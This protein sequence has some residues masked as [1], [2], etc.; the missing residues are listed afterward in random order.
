GGGGGGVGVGGGVGEGEGGGGGGGGGVRRDG[1]EG[2]HL[3]GP[4]RMT[5][6]LVIMTRQRPYA[7]VYAPQVRQHLRAIDANHHSLIREKIE[8][9]VLFEPAVE[10]TNR[11]PLR[12]PIHGAA[13]ELRFGP[14]NRFRVFYDI[15]EE[16]REV[17]ILAIGVKDRER[18]R[19]GEEEVES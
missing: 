8:E 11:K 3:T 9:Q 7:L 5:T 16:N 17:Q 2:G 14:G 1:A 19:I 18:L 15:D 12:S 6:I 10:T 4:P 13:W